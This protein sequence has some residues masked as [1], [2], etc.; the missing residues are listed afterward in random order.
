MTEK[1]YP[2]IIEPSPKG[3]AALSANYLILVTATNREELERKMA[4]SL[5]LHLYDLEQS[6]KTVASPK[7]VDVDLEEYEPGAQL[8]YI[9]PAE[10]NLISLELEQLIQNSG[11]TRAEVADR[12]GTSASGL[13]RLT[14]PF[15]HGHKLKTLERAAQALNKKLELSF[16]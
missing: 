8:A 15:H 14:D 1:T 16:T 5:A 2:F 11:L 7:N 10:L 6:G 9:K 4:E 12:I 13:K 3:F